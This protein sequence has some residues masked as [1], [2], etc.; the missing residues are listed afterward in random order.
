MLLLTLS[1]MTF[2]QSS[3][4]PGSSTQTTPVSKELLQGCGKCTT[5]ADHLRKE[6]QLL[7]RQV[8][9]LQARLDLEKERSGLWKEKFELTDKAL[10]K[11]DEALKK[12]IEELK[13][14]EQI[15]ALYKSDLANK[16]KQIASLKSQRKWAFLGGLGIGGAAGW[17]LR[18]TITF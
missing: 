12:A 9:E 1:V 7:V 2:A 3:S 5:E 14:N 10:G 16:D 11:S 6:N 17:G 18:G 8:Q 15:K 4:E 13:L